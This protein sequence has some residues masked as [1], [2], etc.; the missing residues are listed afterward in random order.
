MR[1]LHGFDDI[2][3]SLELLRDTN[4]YRRRRVVE[5]PMGREIVVDSRRLLNFCSNDYLSLASDPRVVSA[6]REAAS[7]W[8][9]GSG[10][11]HLICGHTAVHEELEEH[12]A[13]FVQ[14]PRALVY[15]SGYAANVGVINALLTEG[16]HVFED[17]LNH[18]SLLDGGWISRAQFHWYTHS[19]I[20]SLQSQILGE[21][22]SQS[23]NLIVSD[24]TFSM[25]GDFCLLEDLIELSSRHSTWLMIDD[26]HSMGVT[27]IDGV[28]TVDPRKYT[29]D[30]VHVLVGTFGKAFGTAGAFVAGSDDLIETM[31]QRSR[32]YIFTTAMPSAIAAATLCS[33]QIVQHEEWRRDR[34][35]ELVVRF[36]NG[37][38]QLGLQLM[39]STSPIQPLIVGLPEE[40][41]RIS[42]SLEENG[43]LVTAIRPPTVPEGTSRL[44][45]TL[46]AGHTV[47]DIDKLLTALEQ[48]V[49]LPPT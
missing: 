38:E 30:S 8:G 18:A 7:K 19:D 35:R 24:G 40:T 34:L 12:L 33:L 37:A 11:S 4:M 39:P 22:S 6:F 43:C 14:R 49:R 17:R 10:A 36:R 1:H 46:T 31:I 13:E 44:R 3:H 45:I 42:S 27:G 29:S 28:G 23:R 2:G 47:N 5:S 21:S 41:L 26:A 9:V 16:D 48:T 20:N 15:A 25:D 32:N